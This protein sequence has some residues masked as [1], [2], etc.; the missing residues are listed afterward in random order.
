MPDD[1]KLSLRNGARTTRAVKGSGHTAGGGH[2]PGAGRSIVQHAII[3]R[4]QRM[5]GKKPSFWHDDD[6]DD[7]GGAV[8]A[9][10]QEYPKHVYPWGREGENRLRY[11]HV[12]NAAEEAEAMAQGDAFESDADKHA[13]LLA[14]GKVKGLKLDGRWSDDKLEAAI[15]AA[16][17]D[18]GLDPSK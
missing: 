9:D 3:E 15:V 8:V 18:P 10:Y 13:R 7:G 2:N 6:D 4:A 17:H 14:I 1:E 5:A 12:N 11:V 16:G